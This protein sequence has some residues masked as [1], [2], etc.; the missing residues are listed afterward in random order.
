MDRPRHSSRHG[1]RGAARAPLLALAALGLPVLLG[2]CAVASAGASVA[3]A[4]V[5]LGVGAARLTG[6]AVGAAVDAVTPDAPAADAPAA[7]APGAEAATPAPPRATGP[8]PAT[9]QLAPPAG[10][11]AGTSVPGAFPTWQPAQRPTGSGSAAGFGSRAPSPRGETVQP[12]EPIVPDP[13]SASR[14]LGDQ[15]SPSQSGFDPMPGG[16][17]WLPSDAR[18]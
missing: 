10:M 5:D 14:H 16:R 3:G 13:A 2:G 17:V 1:R 18:R 9:A 7:D 12:F 6:R 15:S 11:A 8:A 4:A